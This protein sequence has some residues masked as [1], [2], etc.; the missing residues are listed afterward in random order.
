MPVLSPQVLSS[1]IDL[2][3]YDMFA[4][5]GYMESITLTPKTEDAVIVYPRTATCRFTLEIDSHDINFHWKSLVLESVG[6]D[7]VQQFDITAFVQLL[8][9]SMSRRPHVTVRMDESFDMA[10][11]FLRLAV[12]GEEV[13]GRQDLLI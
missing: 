3:A 8:P 5:F 11:R 7:T 6:L 13:R 10:Q 9:A 12:M 1:F 2:S 4:Y